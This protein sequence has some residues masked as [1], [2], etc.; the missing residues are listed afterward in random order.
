M[1]KTKIKEAVAWLEINRPKHKNALSIQLLED[2]LKTLQKLD[3]DESVRVIVIFGK[4]NF[5][6]GGDINDMLISSEKEAIEIAKKVQS[7]YLKI[8]QISKPIIAYTKGL[9]FGGG[10]ELALV[11]DII[12]S[13]P[14]ANFSLPEAKLG[15]VPGGGATQ[16]LKRV[17]GEQN[18]AYLLFT[19]EQFSAQWML[20]LH[21]IQEVTDDLD[22]VRYI[23][24]LIAE[25]NPEAIKELKILLKKD[26]DLEA[27]TNSFSKLL[28]NDG[29]KGI[30]TFL[31][32][33]KWP[34]W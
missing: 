12:L 30:R 18:A 28:Q 26:M 9:V 24:N 20:S 23:S 29:N 27:E 32:D 11:C 1:I 2:L 7:I 16:R 6:A 10:F 3:S 17:I 19:G 22:R 14:N 33:K 8:S 31:K 34:K 21:L 25:K 5:S 15:I 4:E 13:H